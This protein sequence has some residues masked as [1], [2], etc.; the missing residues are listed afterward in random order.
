MAE[1]VRAAARPAT[2]RWRLRLAVPQFRANACV[3]GRGLRSAPGVR[4][5]SVQIAGLPGGERSRRPTVEHPARRGLTA[6]PVTRDSWPVSI[7]AAREKFRKFLTQK[8]LRVT[9]Q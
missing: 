4:L 6:L 7:P 1:T 2:S 5:D 3:V 8:G 9:K